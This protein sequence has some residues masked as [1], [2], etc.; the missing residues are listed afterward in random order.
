MAVSSRDPSYCV[1]I[2]PQPYW[3]GC[4]PH[5]PLGTG[6]RRVANRRG[7]VQRL[8]IQNYTGGVRT[9]SNDSE[10]LAKAANDGFASHAKTISVVILPK[11]G[12]T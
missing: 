2:E 12:N 8:D 6:C 10:T 11:I 9:V 4:N 5:E 7:N 3:E 1:Q